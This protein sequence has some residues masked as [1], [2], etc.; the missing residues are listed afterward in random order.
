MNEQEFKKHLFE[1]C[2]YVAD[3]NKTGDEMD[4]DNKITIRLSF[5]KKE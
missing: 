3:K 1:C 2:K 5:K 4:I